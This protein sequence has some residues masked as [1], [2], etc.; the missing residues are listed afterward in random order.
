MKPKLTSIDVKAQTQTFPNQEHRFTGLPL[1]VDYIDGA[2]WVLRRR[3]VYV[4]KDERAVAVR[5][6]FEF[7]FA[8]IPRPLYWLYPPTGQA[9]NPYGIA[10]LVHDW[11]YCHRKL[12]RPGQIEESAVTRREADD[13]FYEIMR[14]VGC[15]RTLAWTMWLAVRTGGWIPWNRRKAKDIIP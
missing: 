9:G 5:E 6:G 3:V 1:N 14:Y 2:N 11:L 10:A 12:L 13:M 4:A 8:S 7:D 15:R